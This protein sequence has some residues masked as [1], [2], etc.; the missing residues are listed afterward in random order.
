MSETTSKKRK[1]SRPLRKATAIGFVIAA[2][3]SAGVA[4]ATQL[5]MIW[6]GNFQAG[7][8][9]V[10]ADCQTSGDITAKFGTPTWT[11]TGTVPWTVS[12]VTFSGV[13]ATCGGANY[14][15]AYKLAT[16]SD[17]T[18]ITGGTVTLTND[19]FTMELPAGLDGSTIT[20]LALTI[21]K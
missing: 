8:V 20:N 18:K 16:S 14:D 11:G 9:T 21:N 17:W 10:Q 2:V 1:L 12:S 4:S 15:G 7:A 5:S 19:S 3:L 13:D 6:G